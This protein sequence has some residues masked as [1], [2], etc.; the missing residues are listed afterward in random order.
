MPAFENSYFISTTHQFCLQVFLHTHKGSVFAYKA[1]QE[2]FFS[3]CSHLHWK[4]KEKSQENVW[5]QKNFFKKS[6]LL[7]TSDLGA[8]Y[9][10]RLL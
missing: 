3:P 7:Q 8:K 10:S 9:V 5:S 1:A 6:L 4:L 2:D